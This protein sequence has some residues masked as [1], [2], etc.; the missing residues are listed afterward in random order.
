[1]EY[2]VL[3]LVLL[4]GHA[5]ADYPLQGD[6]IAKFK[7]PGSRL[8]GEL[9]WPWVMGAHCVIHA[10]FVLVITGSPVLALL[11]FVLHFS[12]DVCKC[13]GLIGFHDDQS[14]HVLCKVAWA[15]PVVAS[16]DGWWLMAGGF[17]G[18]A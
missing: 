10:G 6:F 13:A 4:F 11:E 12:I 9:V 7:A 3:V 1:M 16:P 14:L 8:G 2:G 18:G 15:A 17:F 5:L